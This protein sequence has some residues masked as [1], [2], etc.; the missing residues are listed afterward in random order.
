[1]FGILG[2]LKCKLCHKEFHEWDF[3]AHIYNEYGK[4]RADHLIESK[5]YERCPYCGSKVVRSQ[6][7]IDY[8]EYCSSCATLL[9]E[10]I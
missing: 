10:D 2:K 8:I 3:N 6:D 5:H 7:G 1:M 4:V 9:M